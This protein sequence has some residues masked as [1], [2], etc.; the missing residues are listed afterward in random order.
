MKQTFL[1][2]SA[3]ALLSSAVATSASSPNK[4]MKNVLETLNE[5]GGKPIEKLS[6][7]EARLQPTPA[8]A[9]KQ[10]M[11]E[12]KAD[13]KVAS[14]K[15]TLAEIKEIK[16]DGAAGKL[17]ARVYLPKGSAQLP[18]VLYFH[19]GGWVIADNDVYDATPRSL[20]NKTNAIFVAVEYRKGPE[21]KFPAAHDDAFAAYKWLLRNAAAIGGDPKRIAVAGESA[22]ANLALNVAVMARDQKLQLPSH[23]LIIYP[24]AGVNMNTESYKQNENAKPLN[25]KMMGWFMDKY[26]RSA[27]DKNDPRINLLKANLRGLA[28]ATVITAQIDPLRTEGREL[29][30][31]MKTQ[32]VDVT[33]TNYEGVTHEFFG[34]APV[35]KEARQ[36]QEEASD[37]LKESFEL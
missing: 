22:G 2:V 24:V 27:E 5:K 10:V 17:D 34:M 31:R 23:E 29:A 12:K 36:A 35:L 25:K 11:S 6:P 14:P 26:L 20:A 3:V 28:P 37:E 19:G 8:D 4:E 18:V 30:L 9:V 7:Q 21:H 33:Y 1:V 16:V 15:N 13:D 32:G